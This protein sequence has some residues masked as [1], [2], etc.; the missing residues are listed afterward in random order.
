MGERA[1]T[2]GPWTVGVE[3]VGGGFNIMAGPLRVAHTSIQ[4]R[5]I[6]PDTRPIL[7][8]EAKANGYMAASAPEMFQAL[9]VA[10]DYV[11]DAEAEAV[12]GVEA[13]RGYPGLTTQAEARL[14]ELRKDI[15]LI[16]AALAKATPSNGEAG[17][18]G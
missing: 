16:D 9:R 5:V 8:D 2:P 1:H 15:A 11:V 3:N 6:R 7:E 10:R 13:V 17:D 4:T 14:R 18:E 12:R